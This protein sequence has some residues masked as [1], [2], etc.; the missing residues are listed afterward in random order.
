MANRL[1]TAIAAGKQQHGIAL[2]PFIAA[3]FPDLPTSAALVPALADAGASLVEV[4]FP[5]S[6]PVADG[7]V[8]Q[9]AFTAALA[10][11]IKVGDIFTAFAPVQADAPRV[12]MLS[13]SMVYRYGIDRFVTS[14][15][16][17]G[18]SGLILPDLPPPEAAEICHRVQDGG[19]ETV[20][21]VSPTTPPERRA[22]IAR[23]CNGFVYYLSLS[24]ITGERASLPAD[25][26]ANVR[27]LKDLTDVPVCVGFGISKR[28]HVERLIGI[29]DGAIVGSGLVRK[30]GSA[31]KAGEDVGTVAA[32]YCR[33]LLGR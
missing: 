7:P 3:G 16:A 15:V 19:L 10:Q 25:L 17:A 21:L 12:A 27:A 4:G 28:E 26:E 13:Y 31:A 8:I 22:L 9:E 30:I 33:E 5:F 29:A 1:A 23:L 18:F 14:A 32:A 24:G 2:M 20:L 6:D 11:K